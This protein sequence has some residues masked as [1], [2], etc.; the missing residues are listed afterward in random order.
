LIRFQNFNK[1]YGSK[2]VISIPDLAIS[3]G[4]HFIKGSNGSGKTTLFK[5]ISAMH[6][7]QGEITVSSI[8]VRK[9]PV[10]IRRIVNYSEAEPAYPMFLTGKELFMLFV[11]I[12]KGDKNNIADVCEHLGLTQYWEDRIGNYSSG[13]IKKLSLCLAFCGPSELI[14]LDEPY[15]SLDK[16]AV[17]NLNRL[18]EERKS[19]GTN[20][21][22]SSHQSSELIEGYYEIKDKTLVPSHVA[23]S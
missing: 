12:K 6:S 9:E 8:N 14:L 21:L 3:P 13:M 1:S 16:E 10:K 5:C 23:I 15:N 11:R 7:F 2:L 19:Q 18:I 22:L 20:F 4:L 17:K